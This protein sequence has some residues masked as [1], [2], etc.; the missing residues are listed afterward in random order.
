MTTGPVLSNLGFRWLRLVL[1]VIMVVFLASASC[2]P[3]Q[4]G[5]STVTQDHQPTPKATETRADLTPQP[6]QSVALAT[7]PR[8]A[9]TNTPFT[10]PTNQQGAFSLGQ[11]VWIGRGRIVRAVFLPGVRQVAIAWGNGISLNAVDTGQELWY[12]ATPANIIA[13]DVQPQGQSFAATLTDG[14]LEVFSAAQGEARRFANQQLNADWGDLAWSPDGQTLAFQLIG[15]KRNDPIY[16]LDVA[17]GRIGQ[18]P[19]SQTGTGVIP[20]L[21]WSP[22][23]SSILVAALGED[24]PRFI[25]IKTGKERMRLEY[26][27]QIKS[28]TPLFLPDGKTLA[29]EGPGGQLEL[30]PFPDGA[31]LRTLASDSQLLGRRLLEFPDASN[32]LFVD[33]SGKWIAD[34]GGYEPCYCDSGAIPSNYPLIVWNLAQGTVRA[35]LPQALGPLSSRHRLAAAFDGNSILMLYE[36]GEITRWGFNDPQSKETVVARIGVRPPVPGTLSWSS[37]GRLAYGGSYG[38]AD[39]RELATGQLV[40]QFDAPLESP[41]LSPDGRLVALFDSEKEVEAIY[42]VDDGRLL[43]TLTATAVLGGSAFSPD[44]R[45]LAYGAGRRAQVTELASGKTAILDPVLS[46]PKAAETA[47]TRLIWSPSGQVLVTLSSGAE[48]RGF[49]VLWKRPED[50]SFLPVYGSANAQASNTANFLVQ[51]TFNPAG[52]RVA[53]LATPTSEAGQSEVVVYDLAAGKVQQTF[54]GYLPGAWVNDEELLASEAQY[55]RRLTLINVSDGKMTLGALID[56]GGN[57][58]SPRRAFVAQNTAPPGRGITI[59][60]WQ[61][62]DVVA[63]ARI[64]SLNLSDYRWSPDGLWLAAVGGD[65]TLRSWPVLTLPS[66]RK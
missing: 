6:S 39:V 44:G 45:Y 56:N 59:R 32:A 29:S 34:R 26:P 46:D 61:K 35:Q 33:P 40:R 53:L 62:G 25:D 37:S 9:I 3:I 12:Q 23:G 66:V 51:V 30:L 41:T 65:G 5:N 36:S 18:V 7:T 19:D 55:D 48:D 38:G 43:Q 24:F 52:S 16:L 28:S 1:P 15:D 20:T 10:I 54:P 57:V 50:G 22:D 60:E 13:F 31:P 58:Y 11:P 21:V 64:D 17:S 4:P 2:S 8:P 63:Q 42:Q 14:S 49:I 47:I 27:G